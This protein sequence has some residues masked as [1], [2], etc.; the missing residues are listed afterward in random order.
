MVTALLEYFVTVILKACTIHAHAV[1]DKI[2]NY[3]RFDLI[4]GFDCLRALN[5]KSGFNWPYK[6]EMLARGREE[7]EAKRDIQTIQQDLQTIDL[8]SGLSDLSSDAFL[9]EWDLD[10]LFDNSFDLSLQENLTPPLVPTVENVVGENEDF[11]IASQPIT[12]VVSAFIFH[13]NP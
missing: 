5:W 11:Y 3:N 9:T 6:Q 12:L 4:S 13:W 7:Q 10:N 1:R 8:T 2:E